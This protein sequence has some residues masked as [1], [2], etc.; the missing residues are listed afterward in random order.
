MMRIDKLPVGRSVPIACAINGF[1]VGDGQYAGIWAAIRRRIADSHVYELVIWRP[2]HV[3]CC[4]G[5]ADHRRRATVLRR[6]HRQREQ[7][8]LTSESVAKRRTDDGGQ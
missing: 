3:G 1:I 8:E 6:K 5:A 7:T 4:R 2:K